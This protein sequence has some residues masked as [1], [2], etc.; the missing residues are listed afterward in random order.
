MS[1]L[2]QRALEIYRQTVGLRLVGRGEE[3]LDIEDVSPEDRQK[4]LRQIN[5][6]IDRNRIKV[7]SNTFSITAKRS[8]IGLPILINA[9]VAAVVVAAILTFSLLFNRQEEVLA[10]GT[11]TI[12]SAESKLIETLREESQAQLQNKDREIL[13]VQQ[14]LRDTLD[15][16]KLLQAQT[17]QTLRQREDELE[18]QFQRALEEE[19]QR[20]LQQG[21]TTTAVEERLL[22]F[23]AEKRSE[24]E[25]E[26]DAFRRQT[27]QA[28]AQREE[29]IAGLVQEYEQELQ[30]A[31]A[32]R[33]ELERQLQERETELQRQFEER[34][35][36]LES[37]RAQVAAQLS[38]LQEQQR[39]EQ[40][41]RDQILST[42]ET[43]N[44][45]IAAGQ[46]EAALEQLDSLRS[47]LNQEPARSLA[48]IQR[49][50]PVEL[51]IIS[52]LEDLIQS[53]SAEE[54][55]DLD[56]LVA[57]SNRINAL[58]Q[59]IDRADQLL[60]QGDTQAARQQYLSALGQ[61]PSARQG[62][63]KL[64]E[65]DALRRSLSQAQTRQRVDS[66]LSR[67]QSL[68]ENEQYGESL[69]RY[70]EALTLLLEDP[71][72]AGRI[73]DQIAEISARQAQ[74]AALAAAPPPA[75]PAVRQEAA[76]QP[77]EQLL[78]QLQQS[79][80]RI[81]Q[82]EQ[83]NSRLT[84]QLDRLQDQQQLLQG[85]QAAVAAQLE[86]LEEERAALNSAAEQLRG[87][88]QTLSEQIA[89]LQSQN[90]DL[91]GERDRLISQRDA[92]EAE[93][94]RLAEAQRRARE[95]E[96]A[97]EELRQRLASIEQRYQSRRQSAALTAATPPATLA[98]LLE[99]KL[100][101]WQIIGSDPVAAQY[102]ELYDTMEQYLD[103]LT[104]QSRLEGRYAAVKDIITVVDALL[105]GSQSTQVPTDLWRRYSYTDQEDLLARLLD[106]LE[107]VLK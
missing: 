62:Y 42:Y 8:G 56:S 12:L 57:A 4:I 99:A 43:V 46:F 17:E 49:R 95:A 39:Q 76:V 29:A 19:R 93:R 80:G 98:A 24:V 30:S 82:L 64:V 89:R 22:T 96:A 25:A 71:E 2:Y 15:Q 40:L 5:E 6:V 3:G 47:Y 9:A 27:E 90:A 18:E 97:R 13:S 73:V 41:V 23:Q 61:I 53:R 100:L 11:G 51:F 79:R 59:G 34:T 35:Q 14:R 81:A 85:D 55:R 36:A 92:L 58:N 10:A 1:G 28:A 52:S 44:K 83:E 78:A 94:D 66:T 54:E 91:I 60:G 37:E 48:G 68:F 105:N 33:S 88:K 72:A 21:L 102:P 32:E 31:Q 16:Q 74:A 75:E 67:S 38:R 103:T 104:E 26:F 84:D 69:E 20:L 70:R 87:E 65:I 101:T 107:L 106:R 86:R 63:D 50:R 7:D 77:D 45:Q